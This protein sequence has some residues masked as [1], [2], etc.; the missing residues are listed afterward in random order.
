MTDWQASPLI[1]DAVIASLFELGGAE[2]PGLFRE[3]VA[4]YLADTPRLLQALEESSQVADGGGLERAAH[5]LKSSSANMGA[6]RLSALCKTLEARARSRQFDEVPS[7]VAEAR[8]TFGRVVDA[9][10]SKTDAA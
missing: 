9:L 7:L 10:M 1:D 6:A 2:D 5:T 8:E 4:L 3:L